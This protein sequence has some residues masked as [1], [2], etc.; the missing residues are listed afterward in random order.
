M[1]DVEQNKK[2]HK[3]LLVLVLLEW[4]IIKYLFQIIIFSVDNVSKLPLGR[5]LLSCWN[6]TQASRCGSAYLRLSEIILGIEDAGW[7]WL[8]LSE[9]ISEIIH[10]IENVG[11]LDWGCV[12]SQWMDQR[13][14]KTLYSHLAGLYP[15]KWIEEAF[16]AIVK[17]IKCRQVLYLQ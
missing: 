11:W 15:V 5:L 7:C 3:L 10:Q 2:Y 9:T 14:Q 8:K 16:S 6:N 12:W 17:L 4:V 13:K 1:S